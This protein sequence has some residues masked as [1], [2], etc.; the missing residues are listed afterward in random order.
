MTRQAG[1][2]EEVKVLSERVLQK[3]KD[4]LKLEDEMEKQEKQIQL[5]EAQMNKDKEQFEETTV[6]NKELYEQIRLTE[7]Q[8][9]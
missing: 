5:K 1:L 2:Q 8:L 3:D 9:I 6:N 7:Q 4:I